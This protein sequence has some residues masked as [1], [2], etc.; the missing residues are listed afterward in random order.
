MAPSGEAPPRGEARPLPLPE[1]EMN[2]ILRCG[3]EKSNLKW[4][5][6]RANGGME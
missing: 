4:G 3:D 5:Q 6:R 2:E 1:G